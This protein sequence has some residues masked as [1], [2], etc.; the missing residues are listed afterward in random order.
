LTKKPLVWSLKATSDLFS[1]AHNEGVDMGAHFPSNFT[2]RVSALSKKLVNEERFTN[3]HQITYWIGR[4]LEDAI[5]ANLREPRGSKKSYD[6]EGVKTSSHKGPWV[7]TPQEWYRQNKFLLFLNHRELLISVLTVFK[8][9]SV[10]ADTPPAGSMLLWEV[11]EEENN[12]RYVRLLFWKPSQPSWQAK[13]EKLKTHESVSDLYSTGTEVEV[14]PEVCANK[15]RC[16]LEELENAYADWVKETGTWAEVCGLH[17]RMSVNAFFEETEKSADDGDDEDGWRG[18]F[19]HVLFSMA[20]KIPQFVVVQ[21]A[22]MFMVV[23]AV[24]CAGMVFVGVLR[25]RMD[26]Y[27]LLE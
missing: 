26:D 9:N 19:E 5:F 16:R 8:L 12:D 13:N 10:L 4:F 27:V 7:D 3:P 18:N 23:A 6:V 25:R 24:F 2:D 20:G 22:L 15:G 11:H 21:G 1:F 17:A 14:Y